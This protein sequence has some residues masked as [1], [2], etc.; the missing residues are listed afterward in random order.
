MF[1][2]D[3][4]PI[5]TRSD[6]IAF[7][8]DV[9]TIGHWSLLNHLS[10][11]TNKTKFMLISRSTHYSQCPH[12]L[13]DGIK[14]EQVSHFKYLRVWISADLTWSKHIM[15]VTCKVRWLLGYIF[16]TFSPSAITTLYRAQALPILDYSCIIWD[17]H[18]QPLLI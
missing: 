10:L 3:V 6:I 2:D 4:K 9:D 14:L 17:P 18:R 1:A 15:L 16:R 11:N 5:T 8:N 12:I 13:P 7:Q